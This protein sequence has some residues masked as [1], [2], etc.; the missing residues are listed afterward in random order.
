MSFLDDILDVGSSIWKGLTG[1][2]V[3]AGIAK[4]TALGYLLKEVTSSINKDNQKPA[5]ADTNKPDPGVRLQ[6]AP[7]T[8]HA[9][10]IVYGEAF[11][12]GIVTDARLVNSNQT[13]WYCLTLC[14]KTGTLLSDSSTSVITFKDIYW[15]DQRLVFQSD[16]ITVASLI[17]N[18]GNTNSDINGLVRIYCFNNG[19]SSPVVPT[20]YTNGSLAAAYSVWAGGSFWTANH[21]MSDLVFALVRIDYNKEKN[22]TGL[23]EL[24]FKLSNTMKQPGDCLY[25][26]MT[27]TRYGAGI[28][29]AE[30]Y[31]S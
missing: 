3:G 17:D 12:G 5:A 16:G 4:A 20:G 30:I 19:S 22:I 21:T 9:I 11:L 6:V 14:E 27:N 29:S 24:T 7:D 25:D 18:D 26:Y 1:P 15:G 8:N 10:P 13:M 28:P 23:P 31:S 2:G